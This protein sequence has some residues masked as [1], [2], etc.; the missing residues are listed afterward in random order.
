MPPCHASCKA[1]T[2]WIHSV[3]AQATGPPTQTASSVAAAISS[4]ATANAVG[5]RDTAN[6]GN[7]RQFSLAS[8]ANLLNLFLYRAAAARSAVRNPCLLLR[9]VPLRTR[10]RLSLP[11]AMS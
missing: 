1:I 11:L 6:K 7:V 3:R 2:G 8:C 4:A 9:T 5:I 10:M